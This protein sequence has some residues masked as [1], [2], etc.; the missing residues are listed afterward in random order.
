MFERKLVRE[1]YHDHLLIL[2]STWTGF[3]KRRVFTTP[4]RCRGS[5]PVLIWS[6]VSS[7]YQLSSSSASMGECWKGQKSDESSLATLFVSL[8]S[9]LFVF[10]QIIQDLLGRRD[11]YK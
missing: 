2:L 4:E 9:V 10:R 8:I 11:Q 5:H 3:Q 7:I 6:S 1:I